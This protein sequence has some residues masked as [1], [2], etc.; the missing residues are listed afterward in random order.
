MVSSKIK[1]KNH[2][3]QHRVVITF[4]VNLCKSPIETKQMI[5]MVGDGVHVSRSIAF[6]WHKRFR[7]GRASKD[8]DEKPGRPTE[9]GDAMIDDPYKKTVGLP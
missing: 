8:G 5:Y 7:D 4:C 9:I 6:K 1:A 2:N 3:F